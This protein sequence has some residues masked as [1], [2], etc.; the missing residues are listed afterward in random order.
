MNLHGFGQA[1]YLLCG[2]VSETMLHALRDCKY[3]MEVW[4]NKIQ[5]IILRNFFSLDLHE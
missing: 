4:A 3:A 1:S 5:S 2:N